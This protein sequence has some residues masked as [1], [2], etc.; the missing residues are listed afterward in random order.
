ME[1]ELNKLVYLAAH[2]VVWYI[3]GLFIYEWIVDRFK[4][5]ARSL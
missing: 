3:L 1:I 2:C 4:D 5:V